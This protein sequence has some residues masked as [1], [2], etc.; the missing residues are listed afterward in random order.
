MTPK[1]VWISSLLEINLIPNEN[2]ICSVGYRRLWHESAPCNNCT[3]KNGEMTSQVIA[4]MTKWLDN[5]KDSNMITFM[6]NEGID[7]VSKGYLKIP[8]MVTSILTQNGNGIINYVQQ[9]GNISDDIYTRAA[10][11]LTELSS[12]VRHFE[13]IGNFARKS[14]KNKYA[15]IN[16]N[17]LKPVSLSTSAVFDSLWDINECDNDGN[18]IY[19]KL[20][21]ENVFDE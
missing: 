10:N 6:W 20:V 7:Q 19:V 12:P 18:E 2:I 15:I 3:E 8:E 14:R 1:F 11:Q 16:T 9:Y 21:F 13:Q 5:Y 17:D 4:N